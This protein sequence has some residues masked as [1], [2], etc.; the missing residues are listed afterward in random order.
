MIIAM[1]SMREV[2]CKNFNRLW[3][4]RP[5]LSALAIAEATGVTRAMPYK[6]KSGEN[7]PDVDKI[8]LLAKLFRVDVMEFYF[9]GATP[10]SLHPSR[11]LKKYLVI[12]DEV[13]NLAAELSDDHDVIWDS[14]KKDLKARLTERS[15]KKKV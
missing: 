8:D 6:W 4:E 2:V 11:A 3:A 9:S 13:V 14:I 5:D 12:P 10:I 1:E 15:V 7:F